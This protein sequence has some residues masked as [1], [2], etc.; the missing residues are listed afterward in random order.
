MIK[1]LEE[2]GAEN[3]R[4]TEYPGE[5]HQSWEMAYREKELYT[6]LF[7]QQKKVRIFRTSTLPDTRGGG[8]KRL[9]INTFN[10]VMRRLKGKE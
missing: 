8:Q 9:Y 1:A 4:Y 6:W 2:V 5:K 10:G 3:V 7:S